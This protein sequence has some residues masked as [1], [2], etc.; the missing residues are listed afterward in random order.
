M[1]PEIL[2]LER[3]AD[4]LKVDGKPE[5]AIAKL[6][7]ALAIDESFAR[8]H[9][10]LSVLFNTM[11][12]Y[13]KSVSHAERAVELEPD[14]PFNMAALSVTY[15][16]AFEGTKDPIFIQKAEDALARNNR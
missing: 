6:E 3:E 14:D 7:A 12:N 9:L 2:A 11:G 16:R 5:E 8:A 10:G 1:T 4:Q 13:E 15:Q